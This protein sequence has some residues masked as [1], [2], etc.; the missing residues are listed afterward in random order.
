VDG[1]F[2]TFAMAGNYKIQEI[3]DYFYTQDFGS[4]TI[5][6]LMNKEAW[7]SM[8]PEDQKIME[9][10]WRDA[11]GPCAKGMVDDHFMGMDLF[12][13]SKT[14]IREPT[15]DEIAAWEKAAEASFTKW[16]ADCKAL[17]A[18]N[19]EKVLDEWKKIV[20]KHK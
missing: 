6:I 10:S 9:E 11:A 20:K 1:A 13:A 5:V 7:N 3:A 18:N 14:E 8:P 15:P 16:I 19:P 12:K 4:G 17:G 2:L